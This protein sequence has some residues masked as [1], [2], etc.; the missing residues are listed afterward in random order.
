MYPA[1]RLALGAQ[2]GQSVSSQSRIGVAGST[3]QASS[4]IGKDLLCRGV[5]DRLSGNAIGR[6]LA[7]CDQYYN[8]IMWYTCF[9]RLTIRSLA[10]AGPRGM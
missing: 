10:P 7:E 9:S 2:A 4:S 8:L 1:D 3:A 6:V 5:G